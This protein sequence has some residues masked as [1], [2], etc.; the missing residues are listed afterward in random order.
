MKKLL[1]PV[2]MSL[3]VSMLASSVYAAPPHSKHRAERIFSALELS[4]QQKQDVAEIMRQLRQDNSVYAGERMLGKQQMREL[5]QMPEWDP[6]YA[7]QL[8]T[9]NMSS[10]QTV[11]LNRATAQHAAI[12][13]LTDE[14]KTQL[15]QIDREEIREQGKEKFLAQL[16]R[17]LDLD[18]AQSQQMTTIMQQQASALA[19]YKG[20]IEAHRAAEKT[21]IQS[22]TFDQEAYLQLNQE[23]ASTVI[24]ME[25]IKAK[26]RYD[27]F[28][29]LTPEQRQVMAEMQGPKGEGKNKGKRKGHD[30][31]HS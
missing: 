2:I 9:Q 21:L 24:E 25:M 16:E 26:S 13:V 7:R 11:E 29:I 14:Q 23:F 1:F 20:E 19:A 15:A 22:D 30:K 5:L 3:S 18:S 28:H 31:D 17:R 4:Q 10:R 27:M 8:I 6:D 12:Q